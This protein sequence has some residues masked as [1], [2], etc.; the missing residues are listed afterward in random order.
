MAF[1]DFFSTRT[2]VQ[3][4][5]DETNSG[6]GSGFARV[7]TGLLR[8]LVRAMIARG[9]TAPALYRIVKQVYVDVA[10]SEFRLDGARQTDSRISMLTG[11]HRR[12]VRAMRGTDGTDRQAEEKVTT[13][14][15]VIGRWIADPE[16]RDGDGKPAPLDRTGD[17]SFE[18]LVQA[19]SKDIRPRTVLDELER[20]GL[21]RH[22][23]GQVHLSTDAFLGPADPEQKIFFFAENVGDHISAAVDNLLSDEPRFMERAVF[24]NR[25]T[26]DSVDAIETEARRLGN[27]ALVALNEMANSRQMQDLDAPDGTE[28]FRFGVFFY[29]TDEASEAEANPATESQSDLKADT[30]TPA[31]KEKTAGDDDTA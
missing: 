7:L 27:D 4:M 23:D 1:V 3:T 31:D 20:Q 9:V 8:P 15:S 24:Y 21:V 12:D 26:A 17:R 22:I 25:L 14:A 28:R 19:V 10:E 11:V 29:R 13:I 2:Y 6:D 30:D 5:V 18:T 16:F